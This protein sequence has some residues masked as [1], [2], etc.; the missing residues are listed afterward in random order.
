MSKTRRLQLDAILRVAL[1]SS[2]VYFQPPTSVKM[3]YPAIVYSL[4]NINNDFANDGVYLS[5]TRYSVTLI[6]KDPDSE[7]IG[8]IAALPNCQFD[9]CYTSDNLNHYVF[10]IYY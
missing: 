10:T 1:G 7:L 8:T 4:A 9:R 5:L 3:S 6:V 2:N